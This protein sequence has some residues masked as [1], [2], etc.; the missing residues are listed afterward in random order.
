[1][2]NDLL[3]NLVLMCNNLY[4]AK[5]VGDKIL[6]DFS[7]EQMSKSET[8]TNVEKDLVFTPLFDK[9]MLFD[10]CAKEDLLSFKTW[11][12][13]EYGSIENKISFSVGKPQITIGAVNDTPSDSVEGKEE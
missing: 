11:L 4:L 2:M 7:Q 9:A 13:T 10:V 6:K 8:Y 3:N 1:M 12:N 5:D